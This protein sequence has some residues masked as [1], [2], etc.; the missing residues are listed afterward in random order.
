MD[1]ESRSIQLAIKWNKDALSLE[2]S[3]GEDLDSLRVKLYSLTQVLPDK[4]KL[5]FKGKFLKAG[6]QTLREAGLADVG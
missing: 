1:I 5:L 4:Q 2:V 6:G 3:D